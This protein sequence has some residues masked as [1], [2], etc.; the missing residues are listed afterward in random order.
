MDGKPG[1]GGRMSYTAEHKLQAI[2]YS[3]QI[4]E[5]GKVVGHRGTAA[6]IG[7]APCRVRPEKRQGEAAG[8]CRRDDVCMMRAARCICV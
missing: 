6:M 4:C 3:L 8:C 1:K 2:S 5:D 7:F